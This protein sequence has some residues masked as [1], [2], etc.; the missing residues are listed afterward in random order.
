[1]STEKDKWE[2]FGK[3]D[4]YFAVATFDKFKAENLT[5]ELKSDFFQLGEDQVVKLWCEVE[6]AF[7]PFAPKRALDF[8]CGVGR[9]VI[10]LASRTGHVTGVDISE[11]MIDEARRNC[12][13]HNLGNT[14]FLQTEAFMTE[15]VSKFDFVHS[16]IVFQH[17]EPGAGMPIFRRILN[18]L[19]EDGVGALQFTIS[20]LDGNH[21]RGP[22]RLIAIFLRYISCATKLKARR[23]SLSFLCI[24][25]ILTR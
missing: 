10:P 5:D 14:D 1:M 20:G 21:Y 6:G 23:M 3:N 9:V 19:E 11:N 13:Q 22:L 2:Y 18:L 8:G 7:G 17:I 25:M 24:S 12:A 16:S 15:N 4:P